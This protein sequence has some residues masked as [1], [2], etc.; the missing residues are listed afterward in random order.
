MMVLVLGVIVFLISCLFR[1]S[2]FLCILINIG[3]LLCK[4]NVFVVEIKV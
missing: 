2:V 1:L 4:M 3:M